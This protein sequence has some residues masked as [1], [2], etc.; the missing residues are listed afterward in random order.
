MTPV[1]FIGNMLSFIVY[2]GRTPKFVLW[3]V[4]GDAFRKGLA[5]VLER[6]YAG[7]YI[8]TVAFCYRTNT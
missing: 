6:K 8:T 2:P 7:S 5:I 1:A 3:I 4:N